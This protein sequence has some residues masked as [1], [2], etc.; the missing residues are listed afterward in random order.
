MQAV[1]VLAESVGDTPAV[2]KNQLAGELLE[3]KPMSG[4]E[5]GI[6]VLRRARALAEALPG[7]L[8]VQT[9]GDLLHVF[10][11]RATARQDAIVM[12]LNQAQIEARNMRVTQPRMEEAFISLVQREEAHL[13]E[14]EGGGVKE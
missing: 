10:V 2:I 8:E 12:A 14:E 7:V 11:D 9:Y 4:T 13:Q 6:G 5:R 3:F 1:D